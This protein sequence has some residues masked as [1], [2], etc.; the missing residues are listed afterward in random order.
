MIRLSSIDDLSIS[1][2]VF[3]STIN[4]IPGTKVIVKLTN[5]EGIIV[6]EKH[7]GWKLIELNNKTEKMCRPSE[8]ML[9]SQRTNINSFL[10]E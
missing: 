7:G 4:W 8:L 5:Q 10:N 1:P 2:S 9:A 6:A 3:K